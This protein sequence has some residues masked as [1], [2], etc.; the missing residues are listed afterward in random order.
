MTERLPGPR[1]AATIEGLGIALPERVWSNDAL[2]Q[3]VETSD[4]WIRSRTGIRERRI[5]EPW[6]ATSDLAVTA[7]QE[8]LCNAGVKATEVGMIIVA[9][10]TPDMP[11]PS[12]AALIQD[13][14][15][16]NGSAAFDLEAACSGFI[17]AL[18]VASR[19]IETGVYEHVLIVGAETLSRITNWSDRSTCVLFGDG[20]GA[21]LVGRTNDGAGVVDI[22]M[23]ADGAG[24]DI[25]FLSGGG[26]RRP[27]SVASLVNDEHTIHMNGREVYRWAVPTMTKVALESLA[28]GGLSVDEVD[29]FVPH[30]ANGR[31][32]EAV[33]DRLRLP[34]DRV[35]MNIERYGN[36]SSA[37][38]P[39]A[40]YE[41]ERSG[42][43]NP[44]DRVLT[45]AFG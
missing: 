29:L 41:A 15:G 21:A 1:Y 14:L 19:F 34:M 9:T 25:L 27:A 23:G 10:V 28:A 22:R 38:I 4:E 20:A 37:S 45:V 17:Y 33:A 5:A 32:I 11:F 7:A 3:L 18:D 26:S 36:I 2:T 30:Q 6:Q 24:R 12:T 16:A 8:A 44:G 13:R 35:L 31:I 42:R 39:V 40:L 43:L